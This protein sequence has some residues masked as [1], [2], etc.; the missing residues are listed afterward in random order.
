MTIRLVGHYARSRRVGWL[1]AVL[2]VVAAL[3]WSVR[4]WTSGAGMFA[5]LLQLLLAT[6]A[7][8]AIAA[9]LAGPF[10]ATAGVQTVYVQFA[11]GTNGWVSDGSGQFTVTRVQPTAAN[12]P[13]FDKLVPGNVLGIYDTGPVVDDNYKKGFLNSMRHLDEKKVQLPSE[14]TGTF[15]VF[16][17]F[18]RMSFGLIMEATDVIRVADKVESP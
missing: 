10:G 15:M 16:K 11:D 1:L 8:T 12:L 17:T 14:R 6:A 18:E 3:R 5:V 4:P 2:C 13:L 7:A 9:G